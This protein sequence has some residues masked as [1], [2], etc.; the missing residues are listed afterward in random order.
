MK[1]QSGLTRQLAK[2]F[3]APKNIIA[4]AE[5]KEYKAIIEQWVDN[6]PPEYSFEDPD[7]SKDECCPW[8]CSHRFYVYTM[9]C[10]LILNPIRHYMVKQY[11]W[12]SPAD[13]LEIR[14]VGIW[15]SLKLMET[16]RQWVEKV[17]NRDGRLHFIIFSIFDTAAILCTAIMKDN[18]HLLT[19]NGEILI[20]IGQALEMLRKLNRISK[21]SKT[22]FD[23]LE[24]L[25]KRLPYPVPG[26]DTERQTK[27][28]KSAAETPPSLRSLPPAPQPLPP[29][30]M[31]R[32]AHPL[33]PAHL[34][35]SRAGSIAHGQEAT[36]PAHLPRPRAGSLAYGQES[37]FASVPATSMPVTSMPPPSSM[38]PSSMP[39]LSMPLSSPATS[40]PVVSMPAAS[41]PATSMPAMSM[42]VR[43]M[44]TLSMP[45]ISMPAPSLPAAPA[46]SPRAP[47]TQQPAANLVP[48]HYGYGVDGE[49]TGAST[50]SAN[51]HGMIEVSTPSALAP[52]VPYSNTFVTA[53][54]I[55]PVPASVNPIQHQGEHRGWSSASDD[56]P[57]SLDDQRSTMS[58]LS[59]EDEPAGPERT[60]G[61]QPVADPGPEFNIENLTEAQLGELAPLWSWHS[62][63][64][65]FPT[66]PPPPAVEHTGYS[67]AI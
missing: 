17:Y 15:Y 53:T 57:P 32:P 30:S 39:P 19:N 34:P 46:P 26:L 54:G 62:A 11:T 10:L 21:T 61:Q 20:S 12:D 37:I 52:G 65:D 4:P 38:P 18:E 8:L 44:P 7:T 45:A 60:A 16:M 51:H 2:R 41:L 24:R 5:V 28:M 67:Q 22:S 23:I 47:S 36:Q 9:A 58:S 31:P 63:N 14:A 29:V 27:R 3:S 48:R 49:F 40:M 56:T 64:L 55:S 59:P 6:F 66:F 35:R 42:P 50:A 1:M 33:Q 25:V 13:E 43:L